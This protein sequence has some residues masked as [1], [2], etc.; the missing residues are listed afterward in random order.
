MNRHLC[1]AFGFM[2]CSGFGSGCS[3]PDDSE[4]ARSVLPIVEARCAK[5]HLGDNRKGDLSLDSFDLVMKGGKSGV[6]VVPGDSG[7][8]LLY[9]LV[10]SED[11]KKRMPRKGEALSGPDMEAIRAWI[12]AGAK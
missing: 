11:A 3:S 4:Y 5:C 12:D 7:G 1:L 8:S 9:Q 2:V 10:A 6:V